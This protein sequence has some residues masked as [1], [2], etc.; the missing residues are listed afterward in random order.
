M[1]YYQYTDAH[2]A[3]AAKLLSSINHEQLETLL[4][5]MDDHPRCMLAHAVKKV[6]SELGPI[7]GSWANPNGITCSKCGFDD[8]NITVAEDGGPDRI[9][10]LYCDHVEHLD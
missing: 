1:L 5:R 9:T 8:C 10:C 7:N 3:D 4:A 6:Q 2:L